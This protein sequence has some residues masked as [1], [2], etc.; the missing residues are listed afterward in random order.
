MRRLGGRQEGEGGG[1]LRQCS[2]SGERAGACLLCQE[3]WLQ[4][5][6]ITM[7]QRAASLLS[8][9]LQMNLNLI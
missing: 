1:P 3:T 6:H 5:N 2:C 8:T 9:P 4:Q 7:G